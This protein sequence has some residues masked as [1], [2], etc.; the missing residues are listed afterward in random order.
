MMND[1]K[2][3][4]PPEC[5]ILLIG[6]GAAGGRF[7]KVIQHASAIFGNR[8]SLAGVVDISP[9][10]PVPM[11]VPRFSSLA[12]ALGFCKPD[13]AIV[14]ANEASHAALL[15][16]LGNSRVHTV[17]CEKPLTAT[18]Q[19]MRA[20][21]VALGEKRFALN[22]VERFSPVVHDYFSW[23]AGQ[24]GLQPARV[25]FFWGK[26]RVRD[27]RPT[28]GVI[29]EI[30]HP[31]DLAIHLFGLKN[32]RFSTGFSH[33]SDFSVHDRML[34]DTLHCK[35]IDERGVVLSAHASFAWPD[36][37]RE[38]TAFLKDARGNTFQ[39]HF[40]FDSP[41]WDCDRLKLWK[42][43]ATTGMRSLVLDKSYSND[44]F[45]KELHQTY[46]VWSFMFNGLDDGYAGADARSRVDLSAA[47]ELQMLLAEVEQRI[48][49]TDTHTGEALF[50]RK[51]VPAAVRRLG[52]V[53][54]YDNL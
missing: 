43:S 2:G 20:L 38:I 16:E 33:C 3:Y 18:L 24:E 26:S 48:R 40:D 8:I 54:A 51:A 21:P 12:E 52:G 35:L 6:V 13:A 14:S 53:Y 30:I 47:K 36:R 10:V 45:P 32:L 17:L 44:D 28:I 27:Q 25:Q 42:V 19:E 1:I 9:S 41:L 15:N 11:N 37:R 34:E 22:L 5:R 31:L 50:H 49:Q 46:K 29:S 39:A 23:A 4:I 7:L